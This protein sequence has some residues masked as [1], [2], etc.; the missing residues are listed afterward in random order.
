MKQFKLGGFLVAESS[1]G[2]YHVVFDRRVDWRRSMMAVSWVVIHSH[3]RGL[4]RWFLMQCRKGS[5]TLRTSE[6][7][8][9]HVPKIIYG[10]GKH[11]QGI[12]DYLCYRDLLTETTHHYEY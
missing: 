8:S 12:E 2:C 6:K 1:P 3:H 9:K 10:E 5:S 4:K 7:G 11:G